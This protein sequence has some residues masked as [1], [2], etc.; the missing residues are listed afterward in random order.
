VCRAI[1]RRR[2]ALYGVSEACEGSGL[3]PER[4]EAVEEGR[5]DVT[6]GEVDALVVWLG[7]VVPLPRRGKRPNGRAAGWWIPEG[8]SV[9][10]AVSVCGLSGLYEDAD[11]VSRCRRVIGAIPERSSAPVR[12]FRYISHR[13]AL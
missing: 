3:S 10:G 11:A 9:D 4:L 2:A 6:L 8:M 5:G 12:A 13:F 1:G 7:L